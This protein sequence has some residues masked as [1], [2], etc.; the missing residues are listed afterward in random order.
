MYKDRKI[1]KL[2]VLHGSTERKK[3]YF[4]LVMY[5]Y[6]V[7]KFPCHYS[8]LALCCK[9]ETRH[10]FPQEVPVPRI[11]VGCMSSL[12][13]CQFIYHIRIHFSGSVLDCCQR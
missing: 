6:N 1:F 11:A 13:K 8:Q 10:I 3:E 5:A 12:K 7:T 2:C 9:T 4:L